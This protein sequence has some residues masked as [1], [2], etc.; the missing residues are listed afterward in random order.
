MNRLS[1]LNQCYEIGLEW[2]NVRYGL[3]KVSH[4]ASFNVVPFMTQILNLKKFNILRKRKGLQFFSKVE[5]FFL[6]LFWLK[7]FKN[8]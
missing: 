8:K 6:K 5:I 3:P 7:A 4:L 2:Q 1:I